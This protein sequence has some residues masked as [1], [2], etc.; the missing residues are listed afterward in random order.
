MSS[1][2]RPF[3]W[4]AKRTI[5]CLTHKECQRMPRVLKSPPF[6]PEE[7]FTEVLH[8]I[9]I[10]DPYRWLEDQ[11]S[12]RT[13]KWIQDQ[14]AYTRSYLSAISGREKIRNRIEALLAVET[15]S[16]PWKIANRYFF[17]KRSAYQE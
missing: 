9:E 11:N 15:I 1:S 6:T 10:T 14:A 7:P 5:G 17:I 13:R 8:G 4:L 3:Q 16:E 2:A 12:L